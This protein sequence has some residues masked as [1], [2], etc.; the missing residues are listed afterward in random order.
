MVDV[1]RILSYTT[2]G[3]CGIRA[4]WGGLMV[5]RLVG[6][7]GFMGINAERAGLM[8]LHTSTP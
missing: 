3:I 1:P 7:L 5:R 6:G 2:T 8:P 4:A